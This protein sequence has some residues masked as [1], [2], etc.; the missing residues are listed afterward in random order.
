MI[1]MGLPR[2]DFVMGFGQKGEP[3]MWY[4]K[5]EMIITLW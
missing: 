5:L 2:L 3:N 4:F 1:F